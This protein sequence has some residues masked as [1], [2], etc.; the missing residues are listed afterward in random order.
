ML[1]SIENY[2]ALTQR[3]L[4]ANHATA[5]ENWRHKGRQ[6]PEP[7]LRNGLARSS[8]GYFLRLAADFAAIPNL[9]NKYLEWTFYADEVY[10]ID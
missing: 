5:M 10:C 9:H 3:E 1:E 8:T 4:A 6:G 7:E 2:A